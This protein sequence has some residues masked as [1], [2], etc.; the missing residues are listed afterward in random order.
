MNAL[1]LMQ[2]TIELSRSEWEIALVTNPRPDICKSFV[3][4]QC[5]VLVIATLEDWTLLRVSD[6]LAVPTVVRRVI[7]FQKSLHFYSL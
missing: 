1:I 3:Y 5:W 7:G 2:R 6:Q 4:P